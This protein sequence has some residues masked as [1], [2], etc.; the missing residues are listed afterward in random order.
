M[1][2]YQKQSELEGAEGLQSRHQ[3]ADRKDNVA[4]DIM[5]NNY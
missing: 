5:E 3:P 1:S 4:I 2:L